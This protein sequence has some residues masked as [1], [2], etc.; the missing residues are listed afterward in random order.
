MSEE[1]SEVAIREN[2]TVTTVDTET[3]DGRI[4]IN[5]DRDGAA[6]VGV[7]TGT[8]VGFEDPA[9]Q[10]GDIATDGGIAQEVRV[11][12]RGA[13][14]D[15]EL[16]GWSTA[17]AG[18]SFTATGYLIGVGEIFAGAATGVAGLVLTKVLTK[19]RTEGAA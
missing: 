8:H 10:R 18:L 9:E 3:L 17:A 7:P 19:Q 15:S 5:L 4:S 1:T 13:G 12:Q 2:G 14:L 6:A 16:A 11:G